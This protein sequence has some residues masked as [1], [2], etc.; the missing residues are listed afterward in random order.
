VGE[1]GDLGAIYH[2][3]LVTDYALTTWLSKVHLNKFPICRTVMD[4]RP[5]AFD[6]TLKAVAAGLVAQYVNSS[7]DEN[8]SHSRVCSCSRDWNT[9]WITL[10]RPALR[11][12]DVAMGLKLSRR[13]NVYEELLYGYTWGKYE[14]SN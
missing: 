11:L 7:Q 4:G 12:S 2:S 10:D 1:E 5:R 14:C 6:D 9:D 3:P 8:G 13:M